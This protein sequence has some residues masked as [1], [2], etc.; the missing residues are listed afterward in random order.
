VAQGVV[1]DARL[2]H[3]RLAQLDLPDGDY[4]AR[5]PAPDGGCA[6]LLVQFSAD[7]AVLASVDAVRH[8]A[9]DPIVTDID[10]PRVDDDFVVPGGDR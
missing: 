8:A 6:S 1:V 7:E 5:M 4:W 9:A 3:D 2:D 10:G